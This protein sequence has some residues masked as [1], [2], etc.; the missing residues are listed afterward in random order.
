MKLILKDGDV[1]PKENMR[2]FMEVAFQETCNAL[3]LQKYA[4]ES[5]QITFVTETEGSANTD[6]S[7]RN[8]VEIEMMACSPHAMLVPL[9]HEMVHV[10]DLLNGDFV[11]NKL[12][13]EQLKKGEMETTLYRG[14]PV[15]ACRQHCARETG[16]DHALLPYEREAYS[17]QWPVTKKVWANL[18]EA[19]KE[20]ARVE[21]LKG[22][23]PDTIEGWLDG[24]EKEEEKR[25]KLGEEA[26][27]LYEAFD[28]DNVMRE[29]AKKRA[30]AVSDVLAENTLEA[31]LGNKYEKA[32]KDAT[33]QYAEAAEDKISRPVQLAS[34]MA[35]TVGL[36]AHLAASAMDADSFAD[37]CRE[38]FNRAKERRDAIKKR[39]EEAG[40]PKAA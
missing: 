39:K 18:P 2:K 24:H 40:L 23:S 20:Y 17:L 14:Q 5:V 16:F 30:S 38:V 4:D 8:P 12:S 6:M 31:T 26:V 25:L 13:K 7:T 21:Y 10:R 28:M 3:G 19:C 22:R 9:V 32:V 33:Y 15:D 1:S 34:I 37:S 27:Q 35:V 11:F 29:A 36:A